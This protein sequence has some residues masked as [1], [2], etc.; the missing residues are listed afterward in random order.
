MQSLLK[1][2]SQQEQEVLRLKEQTAQQ[3]QSLTEAQTK[4]A[5]FE[6]VQTQLER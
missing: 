4:L 5:E 3:R 6:G 1:D 2:R